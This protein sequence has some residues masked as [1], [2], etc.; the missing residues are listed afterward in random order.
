MGR[1]DNPYDL[2]EA[3][4]Y[5]RQLEIQNDFHRQIFECFGVPKKEELPR[6]RGRAPEARWVDDD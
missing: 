2:I 5:E 3:G 4:F 1:M 6:K